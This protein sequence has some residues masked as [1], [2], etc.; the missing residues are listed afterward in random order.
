[1]LHE[2]DALLS[3]LYFWLFAGTAVL[4]GIGLLFSRHPIAAAINLV[5]TMIALSGIYA[6]LD[7]P[8]IAVLQVLVYAGAI[9]MLVIF[10]IMVLNQARD[11]AVPL[12]GIETLPVLVLPVVLGVVLVA[13]AQQ[14]TGA[15]DAKAVRGGVEPV[16]ATLF[17]LGNNGYWLLFELTGL[18]L[19]VAAVAAVLLA[20]RHLESPAA[21][22]SD[23]THAAGGH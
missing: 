17:D 11:H 9:M 10:V 19:L 14:S 20:K 12:P 3:P 7:S 22:E 15:V 13:A 6:L 2:L 21:N 23:D 16:A 4:C 18:L 8:F 5:G 1:M